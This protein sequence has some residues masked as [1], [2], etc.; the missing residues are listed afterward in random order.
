MTEIKKALK[1]ESLSN[2]DDNIITPNDVL[3]NMPVVLKDIFTLYK[4]KYINLSDKFILN[5][6]MSK[7][8]QMLTGKRITLNEASKINIPNWYSINFI[9]SGYGKDRLVSD[10]DQNIFSDYKEWFK[11]ESNKYYNSEIERI[12][13][14][15]EEKYT[16]S[17]QEKAKTAFVEKETEK[18]RNIEI[19]ILA[20]T[21]E[22]FYSE[23]KAISNAN[24]G[25]AYIKMSELGLYLKSLSN[26]KLQF[27][28]C[29]YDAYDGKINDKCIKSE[30]RRKQIENLPVNALLY[31]DYTLFQ[32]DIK[33]IFNSLV[34]TGLG[35][36]AIISFQ[37]QENLQDECMTAD[38][39]ETFYK[40][41]QGYGKKLF[42]IFYNLPFNACYVLDADA[43]DDVLNAYKRELKDKF[44]STENELL[45][46]EIK[47]RELKAL[48]LSCI[49]A[50]LNHPANYVINAEDVKQAILTIEFLSTDFKE[51]I[52]YRPKTNDFYDRLFNF[53]L[54]NQG[55]EEMTKYKLT[56][57][58]FKQLGISR[59]NFIDSFDDAIE[60][61]KGIAKANDYTLIE[62]S[63]NNNSGMK[64]YLQPLTIGDDNN[65]IPFD[66]V[67]KN[68]K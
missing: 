45:K 20:G 28:N 6:L 57:K 9:P 12:N 36:R 63:I 26:E 7:M 8:C 3:S 67:I 50:C 21:Q 44:N 24:F 1:R 10:L 60:I 11:E 65:I 14:I 19:E 30:V 29:L 46:K 66:E 55:K 33:G 42:S 62:Q 49:Y 4:S 27:I 52:N 37:P 40:K 18:I 51:F 39:E 25:S 41:A 47:S 31:S 48:K 68:K 17:K 22:G 16:G 5:I 35:R 13:K 2:L 58:Y 32:S 34:S 53:I 61:V 43:K 56:Y 15:A 54:E 38:E 64:Y 23:C 59:K